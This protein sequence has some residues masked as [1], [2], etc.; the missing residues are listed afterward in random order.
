VV[1]IRENEL[2]AAVSL[3]RQI[4]EFLDPY[5][6]RK[7]Q[8][9]LDG[10]QTLILTAYIDNIPAGFKIGYG[11]DPTLF[12]SWM[13]G[14]LPQFRREKV[15]TFLA[16][17]QE[18]WCLENGFTQVSVK[19]RVKHIHMQSFLLSR[20]FDLRERTGNNSDSSIYFL[21]DLEAI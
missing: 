13:G 2:E 8:Q 7:Y 10:K 20:G 5:P 4:P 21:K 14:V 11:L 6:L 19:T 3:S 17:R 15:A 16:D 9:R 1:V 12:Y 18:A